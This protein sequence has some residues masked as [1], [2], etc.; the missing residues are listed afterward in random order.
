MLNRQMPQSLEAEQSVLGSVLIDSRCVADIIGILKPADFYLQQNRE[1]YEA[2]YAM[3][4]FS[5]TIDPVT[6]LD[7]LKELGYYHEKTRDYILQL[8]EITPTAANAVRY[9]NIV[10][11]KAMLRGL[12]QAAEEIGE[13]VYSQVG[14]PAEMLESAEK[15]IYALRK[16]E[17]GDS[18]EHIGT[19]LHKVYDRLTELAQSDSAIPGLS[20][21]LQDLDIK[22]NGLNMKESQNPD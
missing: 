22:I 3:F 19:I 20:S 11:D 5:Q 4:N 2:I 12:A 13:T 14:T 9:A 6:V 1:I 17:R 10:R 21:G 16:G 15:K 18:L 8:M 7:K